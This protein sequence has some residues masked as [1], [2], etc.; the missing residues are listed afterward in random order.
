MSAVHSN[1]TP[2]VVLRGY[3]HAKDENRPHILERV[4]DPGAELVVVNHADSI[5]FP[6]RTT[7]REAITNVLV[8]NFAQTY[9]NIYSFYLGRP[10]AEAEKFS[11][12]WLVAMSEKQSKSARVGCGRYD[13]AFSEAAPHLATHLTITI[14][15]MQVLPPAELTTVLAWVR[16][17]SYPWC[18]AEEV[19]RI[20]PSNELLAPVLQHLSAR[21]SGV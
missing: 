19:A 11:C 2:E 10:S 17:L 18:T 7:G 13:W 6:A 3:F 5:S 1:L 8:R 15:A 9:E 12:G 14:D 4:F 21:A 16:A 20:A